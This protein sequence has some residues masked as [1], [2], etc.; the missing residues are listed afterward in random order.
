MKPNVRRSSGVAAG[1]H[2]GGEKQQDAGDQEGTR[3]L[4]RQD[5]EHDHE[6]GD[7]KS[8]RDR[9]P[10][11][12]DHAAA[13]R[14]RPPGDGEKEKEPEDGQD[15]HPARRELAVSAVAGDD[16]A[17]D[18][19]RQEEG[20]QAERRDEAGHGRPQDRTG[21]YPSRRKGG[22]ERGQDEEPAEQGDVPGVGQRLDRSGE[23]EQRGR[24]DPLARARASRPRARARTRERTTRRRGRAESRARARAGRRRGGSRAGIR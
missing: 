1:E 22:D 10:S 21:R 19:Q 8:G 18:P 4:N 15:I 14:A 17:A 3:R 9:A 13:N 5:R 23:A 2:R 20:H 11:A 16:S 7:A 24:G 6:N 12:G